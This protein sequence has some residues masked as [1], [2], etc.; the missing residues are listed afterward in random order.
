MQGSGFKTYG[1]RYRNGPD[2]REG[3]FGRVSRASEGR[4]GVA[5]PAKTVSW[6]LPS[7]G[8]RQTNVDSHCGEPRVDCGRPESHQRTLAV[9]ESI[10]LS[11]IGT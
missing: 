2:D 6:I 9:A 3:E 8:L 5:G 7:R 10:K 4:V 1:N 11:A